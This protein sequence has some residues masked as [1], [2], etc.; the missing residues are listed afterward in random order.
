VQI[1]L[2]M[3]FCLALACARVTVTLFFGQLRPDETKVSAR[4][5]Q[6][7]VVARLTVVPGLRGRQLLYARLADMAIYK[8]AFLMILSESSLEDMAIWCGWFIITGMLHL[9]SLL[10]RDRLVHVRAPMRCRW[11]RTRSDRTYVC[12]APLGT[13]LVVSPNA[14]IAVHLRIFAL[15]TA[16]LGATV[17]LV[18]LSV[19]VSWPA[20]ITAVLILALEVRGRRG[21]AKV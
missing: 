19:V 13:Q 16:I 20:G 14:S 5:R 15:L 2:N 7:A 18:G 17:S 3:C 12:A 21:R 9:V 6:C 10:C 8:G 4:R 11:C 1:L